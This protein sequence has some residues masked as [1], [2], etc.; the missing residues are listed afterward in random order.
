MNRATL[1]LLVVVAL[2]LAVF[3]GRILERVFTP[4]PPVANF[5]FINSLTR[6]DFEKSI[7][8][9]RSADDWRILAH[10]YLAY[11]YFSESEICYKQAAKMNP[12]SA[13]LAHEYGFC[14][15]RSG[16]ANA[17]N[18]EFERALELG[19][20]EPTATLYF[21]G[22]N[23]L[24]NEDPVAAEAAFR[25]SRK[26]PISRF[27]LA[28]ILFRNG[29]LDESR[30]LLTSILEEKPKIMR[31][32]PLLARIAEAKGET[33]KAIS[34]S[35]EGEAAQERLSSPF[36]TERKELRG[37]FESLGYEKRIAEIMRIA[38]LGK[39]ED[40]SIEFQK[41]LDI[42]WTQSVNESLI[43][44]EQK[45]LYR[46]RAFKQLNDRIARMGPTTGILNEKAEFHRKM[47]EPEKMLDCLTKSI[48]LDSDD[49]TIDGCQKMSKH[50]LSLGD[51]EKSHQYQVIGMHRLA[52]E[53]CKRGQG[54]AVIGLAEDALKLIPNDP[55]SYYLLGKGH[56]LKYQFD[57][58]REAYQKCLELDPTFGRAI[59][60]MKIV[61]VD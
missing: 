6:A 27:E 43:K 11:G 12:T 21:I 39:Y 22:R 3:G 50:F 29:K 33:R 38:A 15:S 20:T 17:A 13:R 61:E 58:A 57:E 24:R 55:A 1:V 7:A 26:L 10:R 5:D 2:E 32:H 9:C 36:D 31:C 46:E 25:K 54:A 52:K 56:R 49:R 19:Y 37:A 35:V 48:Q 16:K 8:E 51:Q 40:T 60:E 44:F 47:L 59:R 18:V 45:R 28:K 41:L 34:L 53:Y 4:R 30:E 42:E 23:H 14:L